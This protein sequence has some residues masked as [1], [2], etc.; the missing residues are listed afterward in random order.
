MLTY[1]VLGVNTLALRLPSA[2]L[3]TGAVWLTYRIGKES[4]GACAGLI[5]ATLQAFTPTT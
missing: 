3:S 2:V 5:A 4:F 1:A